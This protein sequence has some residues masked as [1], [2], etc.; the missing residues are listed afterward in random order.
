LWNLT[1][2]YAVSLLRTTRI[3]REGVV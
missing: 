3:G 1:R 2:L